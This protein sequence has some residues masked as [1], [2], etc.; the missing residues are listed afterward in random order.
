M[1]VKRENGKVKAEM[2]EQEYN[3]I[4]NIL[5]GVNKTFRWDANKDVFVSNGNMRISLTSH[6]LLNRVILDIVR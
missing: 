3:M 4:K 1:E 5:T 2:S 6:Y